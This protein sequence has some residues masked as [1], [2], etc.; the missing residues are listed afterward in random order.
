MGNRLDRT[1]IFEKF[2]VYPEQM[3][4]YLALIGDQADNIPGIRGVGPKTASAWLKQF[5]NMETL[6]SQI[7]AIKPLRFQPLLAENIALLH[8]NQQ[9]ITLD[10]NI[11]DIYCETLKPNEQQYE[12]LVDF[13]K[14]TS[15]R[16]Y[17]SEPTISQPDLFN[18]LG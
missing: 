8:R 11:D 14:L 13:Y 12:Q 18:N 7:P 10:R 16:K 2:G 9:L 17:P 3:V 5:G 6:L 4:D 15:L 1:G